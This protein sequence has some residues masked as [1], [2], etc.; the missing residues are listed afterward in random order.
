MMMNM[1]AALEKLADA[2]NADYVAFQ[3]DLSSLSESRR[4]HRLQ[5]IENFKKSFSFKEG[6]KYIKVIKD[7]S[8]WGF[9]VNTTDDPM[10]RYGDILKAASWAAPARNGAR[11]NVFEEYSVQWTGPLYFR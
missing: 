11:G 2:I 10:F 6:K 1:S 5:M 3:G 7:N 9:V 8:V 4:A